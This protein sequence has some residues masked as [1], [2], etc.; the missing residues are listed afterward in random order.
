[1]QK[2][3]L[4][5]TPLEAGVI[6]GDENRLIPN[7]RNDPGSGLQALPGDLVFP[8]LPGLSGGAGNA[9]VQ[10]EPGHQNGMIFVTPG[11]IR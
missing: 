7:T 4:R 11:V 3:T 2:Y 9:G 8:A 1:L 6:W 10:A 5:I